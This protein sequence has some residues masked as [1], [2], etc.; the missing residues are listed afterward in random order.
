MPCDRLVGEAI[1]NGP[2]FAPDPGVQKAPLAH[3]T[4]WS[5]RGQ[6][7]AAFMQGF[8][9]HWLSQIRPSDPVAQREHLN[10]DHSN[11]EDEIPRET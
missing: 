3:A 9:R 7:A 2:L 8:N 6:S 10:S 5:G 11:P 4:Y 1:R